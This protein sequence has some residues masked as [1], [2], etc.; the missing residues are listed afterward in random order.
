MTARRVAFDVIDDVDSRDS[1]ANLLLPKRITA[2]G[3]TQQDAALATQ[4]TYG[5]LRWRGQYDAVIEALAE[6]S[7]EQ[8]DSDVVTALRLGLHQLAR[9]RVAGHAAVHETV[10]LLSPRARGKRGFV[11]A[12]LRRV[13]KEGFDTVLEGVL[14]V[15]EGDEAAA[16]RT[17][18]PAWVIRAFRRALAAEGAEGELE[19]LLEADNVPAGVHLV[20]LP[21]LAEQ[22]ELDGA[23]TA[24]PIG[25]ELRGGDPAR[26]P[27]VAD[28]RARVQDS[29]SQLAALALSRLE[30]VKAGERWL[31]LCAGPGGKAALLAA[32]AALH[33]ATLVANEM[34]PHRAKLVRQSTTQFDIDVLTGDGR[35]FAGSDGEFDRVLLDAPCTGLGALR[36]RPESRWRK[37]AGDVGPLSTLQE[38]LLEAAL[39]AVRPGGIVAYVT[40]SP[41]LAETNQVIQRALRSGRAEAIDTEPVLHSIAA[42][43]APARRGTAAQLW[44][45]RHGTD[46]M[47][48]QLMRRAR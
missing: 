8:I 6:R 24:S 13:S 25:A 12:L 26:H 2:A 5:T 34:L 39:A 15:L 35:R 41:H 18:H 9:T 31:D 33:G 44:P 22:D 4:L 30:P 47:F 17:S 32:E 36:R 23:T 20:A 11:N 42:E 21:G 37:Q 45:H 48:I 29:G 16:V 38:E 43:L 10:E 46:A 1:Y 3:L 14:A 19:T 27:L 40:C 7:L 28:R